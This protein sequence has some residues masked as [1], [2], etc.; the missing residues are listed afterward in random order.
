MPVLF[1]R[2]EPD[3]IAGPLRSDTPTQ[4][5]SR[6]GTPS[7]IMK[8]AKEIP[9]G[10]IAISTSLRILDDGVGVIDLVFGVLITGSGGGPVAF[11][12]RADLQ[13]VHLNLPK[14]DVDYQV[15]TGARAAS[16]QVAVRR[17]L[18]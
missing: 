2:F 18:Q 7:L 12:G 9:L 4:L 13:I 8:V 3:N 1:T 10:A 11:Q 6:E 16:Q 14:L 15:L 5:W 17:R